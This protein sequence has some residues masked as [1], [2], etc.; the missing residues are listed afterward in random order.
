MIVRA[1]FAVLLLCCPVSVVAADAGPA[2]RRDFRTTVDGIE[3]SVSVR[4][5]EQLTAFYSGRRFPD[6]AVQRLARACFLTVGIRN[7]RPEVAWLDLAAWRFVGADGSAMRRL[8]RGYWNRV[9]QGT[10]LPAASRATFGWTLLPE[11][12]DLQPGEP[13]GGNITLAPSA[14]TFSLEASFV[15]GAQRQGQVVRIRV[16]GL[17]CPPGTGFSDE[18]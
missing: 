12:R 2:P 5:P 14:A 9:W 18:G 11:V 13:V 6:A 15:T 17:V 8:E 4:T 10:Q 16:P 3:F 1:V 7:T